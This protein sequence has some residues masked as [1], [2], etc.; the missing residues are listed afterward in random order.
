MLRERAEHAADVRNHGTT[1][2]LRGIA[3]G[4]RFD[5]RRWDQLLALAD[6]FEQFASRLSKGCRPHESGVADWGRFSLQ[7]LALTRPAA[8]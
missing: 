5:L 7:V 6:G 3:A 2:T 8:T 1:E 4:L